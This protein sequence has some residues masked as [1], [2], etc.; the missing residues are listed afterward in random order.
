MFFFILGIIPS[1]SIIPLSFKVSPYQV[2]NKYTCWMP[3]LYSMLKTLF[4]K[5]AVITW[6]FRAMNRLLY[7]AYDIRV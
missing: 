6:G 4:L 5:G 3:P 2:L 7:S 1:L